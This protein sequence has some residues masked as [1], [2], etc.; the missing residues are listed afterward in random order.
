[1]SKLVF[2]YY[3]LLSVLNK[4]VVMACASLAA[5]HHNSNQFVVALVIGD[6]SYGFLAML[7]GRIAAAVATTVF[8]L[9]RLHFLDAFF[10]VRL[11]VK[12]GWELKRK[13]E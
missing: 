8:E 1:M 9:L 4:R 12:D 2:V 6:N 7:L 13:E 10:G 5:M 11:H 3:H